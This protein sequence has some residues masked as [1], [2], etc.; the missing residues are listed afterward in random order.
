[1]LHD[2]PVVGNAFERRRAHIGLVQF[3]EHAEAAALRAV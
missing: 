1:M 3:L 2:H